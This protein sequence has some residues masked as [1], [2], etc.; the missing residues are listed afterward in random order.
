[1]ARA[2]VLAALHA[3]KRNARMREN[4]G[5]YVDGCAELGLPARE[6]FMTAV[7]LH[8]TPSTHPYPARA[9]C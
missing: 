4:I 7:T 9:S 3:S 2:A 1:M 5:Q 8:G 6:L